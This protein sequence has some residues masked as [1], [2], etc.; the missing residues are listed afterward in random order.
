LTTFFAAS[1]DL[2]LAFVLAFTCLLFAIVVLWK[3]DQCCRFISC[4]S[5][6]AG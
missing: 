4:G 2:P 1:L 6:F 3:L 5:R